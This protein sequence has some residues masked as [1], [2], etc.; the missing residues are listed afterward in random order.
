MLAANKLLEGIVHNQVLAYLDIDR[1]LVCGL[2]FLY[3]KKAFNMF[4]HTIL[5]KKLDKCGFN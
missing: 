2:I 1:K 4:D 5:L 3:L